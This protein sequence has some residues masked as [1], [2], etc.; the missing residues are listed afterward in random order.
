[1]RTRFTRGLSAALVVSSL[2]LSAAACGGDDKKDDAKK[3][4]ADKPA[5]SASASTAPEAAAPAKPMTDVQ[6]KAA[7]LELKDL[8]SG[9]WKARKADAGKSVYKADKAVCQPVA[10]AMNASFTGSTKGP[11]AEFF[12]GKNTSE[13]SQQLMTFSGT[14][15]A[16]FTK[17]LAAAVDACADFSVETE[18]QKVKAGAKKVTA[19][20]GAEEAIAFTFSM[21]LAPGFKLEPTML[22][23][24]QGADIFR[25]M[26]LAD[27]AAAKKDF[28][29]LA[30]TATDKFVKAAQG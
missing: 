2:A 20:Q 16:D 12:I 9:G 11:G 6:A 13:L 28:D 21:E 19:P 3:D 14:G 7:V 4:G 29:A 26:H 5:V 17:K 18:G 30:K 1:M 10:E 22:V 8:P 15:A 25:L 23:V 24:R 27:D